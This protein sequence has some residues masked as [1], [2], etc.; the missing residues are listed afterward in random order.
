MSW[1]QSLR[2]GWFEEDWAEA[3]KKGLGLAWFDPAGASRH[4]R[5]S[6]QALRILA[7]LTDADQGQDQFNGFE[8]SLIARESRY[9]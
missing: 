5:Q 2:I 7:G 9:G 1:R 4:L 6:K 8:V 3:D